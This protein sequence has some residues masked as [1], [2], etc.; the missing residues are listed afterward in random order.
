MIVTSGRMLYPMGMRLVKNAATQ[1]LN[2]NVDTLWS[3]VVPDLQWPRTVPST[4]ASHG[5]GYVQIDRHMDVVATFQVTWSTASTAVRSV[6]L[7]Y[8]DQVLSTAT[9]SGN[10]T[11]VSGTISGALEPGDIIGLKFN[12]ASATAAQRVIAPGAGTFLQITP[13]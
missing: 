5:A 2:A 1:Q 12:S 6:S 4:D 13:T 9:S 11:V 8:R 7:V 10:H 3:G